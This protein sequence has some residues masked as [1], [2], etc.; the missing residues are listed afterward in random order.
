MLEGH[1]ISEE[2]RHR[3]LHQVA[4]LDTVVI[5]INPCDH[6]GVDPHATVRHH[7]AETGGR[8]DRKLT[9]APAAAP[10]VSRSG[11]SPGP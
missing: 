4:K 3:L 11:S 10:G 5:H 7:E 9:R 2:V 1:A 6:G 8:R